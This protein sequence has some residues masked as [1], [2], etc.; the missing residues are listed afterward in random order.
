M[1]QPQYLSFYVVLCVLIWV[2]V[3]LLSMNVFCL[4]SQRKNTFT[5]TVF[6]SFNAGVSNHIRK[7][8]M[9]VQVFIPNEQK[10]HPSLSKTKFRWN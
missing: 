2:Y 7:G 1:Y 6:Y 10:P 3:I 5:H 8:S 4:Q 9:L